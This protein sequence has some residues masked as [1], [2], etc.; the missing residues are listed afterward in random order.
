MEKISSLPAW[1]SKRDGRLMEFEADKISQSLFAAGE[2]LNLPDAFTAREL[3]D[4]VLHFLAAELNG[5]G[6]PIKRSQV[7]RILKA[8]RINW[9]RPRTWLASDDPDFARKRG[10]SSG[11]GS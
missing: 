10:P 8:E 1:I 5:A 6:V 4:G 3:T 9:Q 7:R 11:S 2:S